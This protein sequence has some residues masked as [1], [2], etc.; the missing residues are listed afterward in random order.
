MPHNT[1][2]NRIPG[3]QGVFVRV[4]VVFVADLNSRIRLAVGN[5]QQMKD[6]STHSFKFMWGTLH[7]IDVN[8]KG[9]RQADTE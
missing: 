5:E 3:F 2:Q 4:L 8:L 1:I 6:V 7:V 9:K